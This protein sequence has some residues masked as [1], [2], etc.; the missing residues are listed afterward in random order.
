MGQVDKRDVSQAPGESTPSLKDMALAELSAQRED[1][2]LDEGDCETLRLGIEGGDAS[3]INAVCVWLR[4]NREV[5]IV[6]DGVVRDGLMS[7]EDAWNLLRLV[8]PKDIMKRVEESRAGRSV[9]VD[10]AGKV[11]EELQGAVGGDGAE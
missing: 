6:V 11:R 3:A 7:K 2:L 8:A 5:C 10:V 9:D 1:G 4:A